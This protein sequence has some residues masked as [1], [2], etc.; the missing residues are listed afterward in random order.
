[1]PEE[2]TQYFYSQAVN[3]ALDEELAR[4]ENVFL[5]G[6]DI[7]QYGGAFGV[8]RG[9]FEKYGHKRLIETP[10]SENSFTGLA[11]GAAMMGLRPVVEIMFMD[12]IALALDQLLN[13]AG[14]LHYM[15]DA[16]VSVPLVLR[17]PGG[18]KGGYGPSH[19]QMLSSLLLGIPGL[20]IVAPSTPRQAKGMLKA[21]IR[22][23]NPVVFI[24]NKRLYPTKGEL[25]EGEYTLPLDKAE[26]LSPGKD[27]TLISYSAMSLVCLAIKEAVL[28]TGLDLE[29][30]DLLSLQ[31]LDQKSIFASVRKTGR[32][33]IVEEACKTGGVGAEVAALIA[34]HCLDALEAPIMRVAAADAP[35]PSSLEL[36]KYVL[37]QNDDILRAIKALRDY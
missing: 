32:V 26:L 10:I 14:K 21:A 33:L 9:L 36:E 18:A 29:V 6:E 17:T 4:D 5:L 31:P 2:K 35:I 1:M 13:S 15:Y 34:E 19:S 20:K 3:Q 11:V 8:T 37:P 27:I 7:G 28:S 30:L 25:P 24:E 12:F 23:D 16:Q 22:D